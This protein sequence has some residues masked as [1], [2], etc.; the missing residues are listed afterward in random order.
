VL[1]AAIVAAL[2]ATS[3]PAAAAGGWVDRGTYQNLWVCSDAGQDLV[4]SGDS[5]TWQCRQ[6]GNAYHLY[7]VAGPWVLHSSYTDFWDCISAGQALVASGS[8]NSWQC[9]LEGGYD[10]LYIV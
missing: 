4:D 5:A 9:L 3:G 1:L 2:V 10:R 8:A 7:T 6:Q